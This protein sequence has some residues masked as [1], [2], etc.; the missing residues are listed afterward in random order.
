MTDAAKDRGMI[1]LDSSGGVTIQL[2]AWAHR[3]DDATQAAEEIGWWLLDS[4]TS[5]WDGHEPE[6]A[7][8]SPTLDQITNGQYITFMLDRENDTCLSLAEEIEKSQRNQWYN[9]HELC[10]ALLSE[11]G[12]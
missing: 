7:S 2:G 12:F 3:Y 4:D 8:L 11:E 5:D 10:R 6:A 9:A 1:I